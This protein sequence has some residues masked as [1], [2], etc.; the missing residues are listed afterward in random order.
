MR[1]NSEHLLTVSSL[2]AAIGRQGILHDVDLA[3]PEGSWFGV[4]G[5]SGAGKSTV[6]RIIMGLRKPVQ[7]TSGTMTLADKT[8]DLAGRWQAP[9]G[10]ACVPQSPA[11]GL[12]PLRRMS[13]QWRQ[14]MDAKG[15]SHEGH[16]PLF[17]AMGLPMPDDRFPHQ[18]SRGMQQ[19]YL[20][21]M[22]LAQKPKL[23]ILD[24]PTSALDAM[25]AAQVLDEVRR[26]ATAEGI[27]VMMVTHDLGLAARF[28]THVA[29]MTQGRVVEQGPTEAV[30]N[31]PTDPYTKDLVA[32][33]HW[34]TARPIPEPMRD[35]MNDGEWVQLW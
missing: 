26:L 5:G 7:P 9:A 32:H 24:E 30:L 4:V 28:A 27:T 19:R 10:I 34:R 12:D 1:T 21:A 2:S 17:K 14:L 8:Y 31:S 6:L 23:I 13:W 18:W 22:A 16:E 33:R 35:G 3:V 25:I 20:L 11:H 15:L 29:I